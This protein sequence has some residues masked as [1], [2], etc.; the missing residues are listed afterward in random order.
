MCFL[1]ALSFSR[2]SYIARIEDAPFRPSRAAATIHF[3]FVFTIAQ[4]NFK[5]KCVYF[6][7]SWKT[8]KCRIRAPNG[9][10]DFLSSVMVM[11]GH[12]I[13]ACVGLFQRDGYH[14]KLFLC[15]L[16]FAFVSFRTLLFWTETALSLFRNDCGGT[17]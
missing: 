17:K 11:F 14:F 2:R 15:I 3:I 4:D 9:Q 5:S 16:L 12:E 10:L 8:A 13:A 6:G 1:W 7:Y